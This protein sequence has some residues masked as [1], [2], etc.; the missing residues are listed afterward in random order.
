MEF[1]HMNQSLDSPSFLFSTESSVTI[2]S[3]LATSKSFSNQTSPRVDSD[4][5]SV[6]ICY[7]SSG[8]FRKLVGYP[9]IC[10]S[11]EGKQDKKSTRYDSIASNKSYLRN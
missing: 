8:I 5:G 11:K 10:E 7:W 4:H 1:Q 2:S 9:R 6:G 3:L